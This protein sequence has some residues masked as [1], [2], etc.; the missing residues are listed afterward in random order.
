[1][2]GERILVS[3]ANGRTGRRVVQALAAAGASVRAFVRESSQFEALR[4][5]GASQCAVGDMSDQRSIEGALTGCDAL[6]HIGPPMHPEEVRFTGHFID[7]ARQAGVEHFVYYSVMHPLRRDVR[8]H[9]LKLEAEEMLVGSGLPYTVL[10][11]S[12]YMQHLEPIWSAVRNGGVHRMPFS[13]TQRFSVVDLDDLAQATAVVATGGGV[14]HFAFY[15]LAGPEAL[16]Q[17]EMATILSEELGRPVRAEAPDFATV[18]AEARDKG[19]SEDRIEQMLVMNRHY[20]RHGFIGNP[21]V[22]RWLL[23]RKPTGYRT[24]VRRLM[25][26]DRS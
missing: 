10:Q 11:P 18:E 12:R 8:H 13:T 14:H 3:G 19:L 24:Y 7:A 1:M 21:N 22:L 17:D 4:R 9:R 15:E 20:D 23:E 16:S 26:A 25:A 5:L 6:V 2:A